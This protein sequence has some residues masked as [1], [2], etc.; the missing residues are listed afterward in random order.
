MS[1]FCFAFLRLEIKST[2][3]F[4]NYLLDVWYSKDIVTHWEGVG[5]WVVVFCFACL[6][7]FPSFCDFFLEVEGGSSELISYNALLR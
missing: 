4:I 1:I 7:G 3:N 5:G 6:A 2:A